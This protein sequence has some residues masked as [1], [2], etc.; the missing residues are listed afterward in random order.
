M[1]DQSSLAYRVFEDTS[2]GVVPTKTAIVMHGILGTLA[3][4]L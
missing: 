1:R 4:S 2:S 3:Q